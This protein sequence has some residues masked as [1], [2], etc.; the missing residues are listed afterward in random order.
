MLKLSRKFVTLAESVLN[1]ECLQYKYPWKLFKSAENYKI[2]YAPAETPLHCFSL[3]VETNSKDLKII[4]QSLSNLN[5]QIGFPGFS[6]TVHKDHC[7]PELVGHCSRWIVVTKAG[8]VDKG[9]YILLPCFS[10]WYS[11]LT[12]SS[13]ASVYI[14]KAHFT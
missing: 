12:Y 4:S 13:Q 1:L 9:Y 6:Y 8:S 10:L 11:K 2:N 7:F 14:M 3:L 5:S